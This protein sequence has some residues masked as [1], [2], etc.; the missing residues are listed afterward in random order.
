M[1]TILLRA[2][3]VLLLAVAAEPREDSALEKDAVAE[4]RLCCA[5]DWL[6]PVRLDM[7]QSSV[8]DQY[9]GCHRKMLQE[10]TRPGGLLHR[11]RNMN[12]ELNVAWNSAIYTHYIPG[13]TVEHARALRVYTME[14]PPVYRS[15]N[16]ATRS[17]GGSRHL[18]RLRYRYKALHFLLTDALRLLK[19]LQGPG[20]RAVYR[21]TRLRFQVTP[22]GYIRFGSFTSTS[23][24]PRVAKRFGQTT[25]FRIT[26]CYGADISAFSAFASEQEVLIPPFEMFAVKSVRKTA[27]GKTVVLVSSGTFSNLKCSFFTRGREGRRLT[28]SLPED[29]AGP[30]G[31]EKEE[32]SLTRWEVLPHSRELDPR[33]PERSRIN[34]VVG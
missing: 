32:D 27:A 2:L 18:Y 22:N 25:F 29:W 23:A 7:A 24:R 9:A 28:G 17:Q 19:R 8:D 4:S 16:A 15:F 11:E 26:T 33:E 20:C 34:G 3:A 13:A 14:R 1:E 5:Q 12:A 31:V 30:S 6:G 10:V 21:G